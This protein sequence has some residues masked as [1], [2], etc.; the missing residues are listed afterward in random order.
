[1]NLPPGFTDE[2]DAQQQRRH[3][4]TL[5]SRHAMY[6]NAAERQIAVGE[7]RQYIAALRSGQ[8]HRAITRCHVADVHVPI[9]ADQIPF[10]PLMNEIEV[11]A[12]GGDEVAILCQSRDRAIIQDDSAFVAH[13][14][15]AHRWTRSSEKRWV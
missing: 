4:P 9:L 7:L 8:V 6:G 3:S 5:A 12:G 13:Q 10:Q 14:R 1:M 15:I 2:T 11:A